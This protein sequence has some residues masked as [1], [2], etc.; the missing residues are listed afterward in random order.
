MAE[1]FFKVYASEYVPVTDAES[2]DAVIASHGPLML[3]F[4]IS[5]AR[6]FALD[7]ERAADEAEA[8]LK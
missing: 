1:R 6:E 4:S 5:S 7:I 3:R 2:P 8:R